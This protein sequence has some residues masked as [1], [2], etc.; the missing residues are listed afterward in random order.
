M[1]TESILIRGV[2]V[3]FDRRT[4]EHRAGCTEKRGRRHVCLENKPRLT[5]GTVPDRCVI[6]EVAIVDVRRYELRRIE[7]GGV[8]VFFHQSIP[9]SMYFASESALK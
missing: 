4:D 7:R 9:E 2:N 3:L 8:L 6:V 5:H 1:A